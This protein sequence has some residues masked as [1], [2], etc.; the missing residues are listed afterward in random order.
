MLTTETDPNLPEQTVAL[1]IINSNNADDA[2]HEKEI[3]SHITRQNPEHRGRIMLR[4][5]IDDFEVTG[6]AGKHVCLVCMSR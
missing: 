6:P 2:Q 3:E 1:K 4:T 5:C